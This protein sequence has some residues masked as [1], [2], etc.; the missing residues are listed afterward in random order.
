MDKPSMEV[1]VC[2]ACVAVGIFA[3][4]AGTKNVPKQIVKLTGSVQSLPPGDEHDRVIN[5][6]SYCSII[7]TIDR[8]ACEK[9]VPK[10][11]IR[12][13]NRADSEM[14][15]RLV[16]VYWRPKIIIIHVTPQARIA[17]DSQE[18]G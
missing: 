7:F 18:E 2:A 1:A 5:G 12:Y 16:V 3:F 9:F 11:R 14:A 8:L 4:A 13:A 6:T 10:P 17:H 15:P